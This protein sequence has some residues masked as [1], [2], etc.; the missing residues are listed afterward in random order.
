V[1]APGGS[2][3][4]GERFVRVMPL[5]DPATLDD[6]FL[7]VQACND[8]NRSTLRLRLARARRC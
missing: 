8:T 3:T 2:T 6:G 1:Q 5:G 7:D 4:P